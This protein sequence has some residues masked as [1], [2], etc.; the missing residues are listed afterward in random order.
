MPDRSTKNKA[1]FGYLELARFHQLAAFIKK[2]VNINTAGEVCQVDGGL[3]G[4][5]AL[6]NHLA[7]QEAIDL[8]GITFFVSLLKIKGNNRCGRVRVEP[9]N[10]RLHAR[11]QS[12]ATLILGFGPGIEQQE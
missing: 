7:A 3:I 9:E 6:L 2:L 5:I 1:L 4:D 11:I 8:D 10:G 12:L